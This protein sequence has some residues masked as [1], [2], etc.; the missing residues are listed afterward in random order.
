[1]AL[2]NIK[3]IKLNFDENYTSLNKFVSAERQRKIERYR[4]EKDKIRSLFAELLIREAVFEEAGIPFKDIS[5]RYG[6]HGK[7]YILNLENY[8]FSVS[9]SGH[10]VAFVSG[11]CSVGIDIESEKRAKLNIAKR[12]FTASE[13]EYVEKNF[14]KELAFTKIWT[15]KEA[16]IKMLGTG[17]SKSLSSFDVLDGSTGCFFSTY[18]LE[19]GFT[20]SVCSEDLNY[21]SPN[22][23]MI[24]SSEFIA[25]IKT[26]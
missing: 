15:L 16:Y 24:S 22:I 25:K 21:N 1:M 3:I 17:L 23:L 4:F 11:K 19:D 13:F 20:V 12:F 5:F 14:N 18:H 10:Y 8:D 6:E 9:H 7:P 26:L 2:N